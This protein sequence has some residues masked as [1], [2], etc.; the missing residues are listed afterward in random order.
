MSWPAN[1][2]SHSYEV[3]LIGEVWI[4]IK[5]QKPKVSV[6]VLGY[7]LCMIIRC[8]SSSSIKLSAIEAAISKL[9]GNNNYE[10]QSFP[11]ELQDRQDL[12][13]NAEPVGKEQTLEYA[14]ER[15]KQMHRQHGPTPDIDISIESGIIDGFDVACVVLSNR[16]GEVAFGWSQG[17]AIPKGMFEEAQVRG[18]KNTSVGDIVHEK[19]PSIPAN[20]WQ[21]SFPPY[22]SRQQQIQ[23]AITL[24]LKQNLALLRL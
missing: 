3:R 14:R 21:A 8:P 6:F 4:R 22:I 5:L 24:L 2:P 9:Y 1:L 10:I 19:D 12:N 23:T 17:I 15:Q 18:L 13:V 7:D 16:D 20:D 11:V